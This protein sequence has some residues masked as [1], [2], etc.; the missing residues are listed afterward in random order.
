MAL[1]Y[2]IQAVRYYMVGV[3]SFR[4]FLFLGGLLRTYDLL[5]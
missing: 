1:L 2:L 5:V 3:F 4:F